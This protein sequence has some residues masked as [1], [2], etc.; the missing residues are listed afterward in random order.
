[1]AGKI[2]NTFKN[3]FKKLLIFIVQN[4]SDLF[5]TIYQLKCIENKYYLFHYIFKFE[6]HSFIFFYIYLH[7]IILHYVFLF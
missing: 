7:Y 4:I 2:F 1:M 5:I 3:I 6:L